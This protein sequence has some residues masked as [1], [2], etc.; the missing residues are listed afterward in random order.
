MLFCS[1]LT[2][3]YACLLLHSLE[4]LG[5]SMAR[6]YVAF[7][8]MKLFCTSVEN[9]S[10]LEDILSILSKSKEFIE[11][12]IRLG[13]KKILN[14]L[15]K[16]KEK[17]RFPIKGKV[18]TFDEKVFILF[19]AALT[20]C[21]VEDWT[22]KQQQAHILHVAPRLCRCLIDTLREKRYFDSLRNALHLMKNLEQQMWENGDSQLRQL[23]GVGPAYCRYVSFLHLIPKLEQC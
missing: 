23:E 21:P 8:T 20:N 1:R 18:K 6:Y 13:E 16:D 3:C 11:C 7:D 14:A 4:E 17:I 22:L 2:M 10:S 15:N 19:Q 5:K 12:N 9:C